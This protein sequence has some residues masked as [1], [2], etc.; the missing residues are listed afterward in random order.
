MSTEEA[1]VILN[2]TDYRETI[3]NWIKTT[4]VQTAMVTAL[5]LWIGYIAVEPLNIQAAIILGVIG[6]LVHI[7]GFT[8]NEVE[9]YKYDARHGNGEGHPIAQGKVH[10]GIARYFAWISALTAVGISALY[11]MSSN[12]EATLVLLATFIPGYM[13]DKWSKTHWWSNFYLS[14]W[15][16][17]MVLAGSLYAGVPTIYTAGIMIAIAIQIFV[18]VI[19][20]DLKDLEGP[21]ASLS[22]RLGVR[23][24]TFET[25]IYDAT[26]A[27]KKSEK[28]GII[29]Y[30]LIF[31]ALVIISKIVEA[32]V[33][34]FIAIYSVENTSYSVFTQPILVGVY[35]ISLAVTGILFMT[36]ISMCMLYHFDRDELKQKASVHELLSIVFLGLVA[37]SLDLY[38]ALLVGLAPIL[39]YLA[40]NHVIHS[41][42]L[43][44]DI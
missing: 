31:T 38:G 40:V 13:Y 22:K 30:P 25:S 7:W 23:V 32:S 5:S 15:A 3:I 9:D 33:L 2:E 18:Q 6:L 21:E 20:G 24:D 26:N 8:L 11:T 34:S 27:T 19:Q 17:L 39:W 29:R 16:A 43:N 28:Q 4:R 42:A 14:A 10:A 12:I 36:T 35:Y 1:N 44:P 37:L 41:D